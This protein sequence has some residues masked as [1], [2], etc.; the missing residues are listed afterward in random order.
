MKWTLTKLNADK[1]FFI[2]D[3]HFWHKNII[4]ICD[5]PFKDIQ[6][7]TEVMIE[8]WNNVV[9]ESAHVF[10][11]GDFALG[12]SE[13]WRNVASRLN[14]QIHLIMG[15]HDYQNARA[16]P[17][18]LFASIHDQFQIQIIEDG[19]FITMNHYPLLTWGGVERGV[20]NVYGHYHT[21]PGHDLVG[22]KPQQYDVGVDSNNY[23][24]IS[25]AELKSIII[26]QIENENSSNK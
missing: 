4:S 5:R 3:T 20:W 8:N 6:E 21:K 15:N 16:I 9:S 14:G 17:E 25:Y 11:L 10:H 24:P 2:S 19:Q 22:K 12:G 1:V 7:M 18:D 13:A 26:K 23:T